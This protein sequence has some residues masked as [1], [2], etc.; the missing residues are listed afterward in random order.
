M[1]YNVFGGTLSHTLLLVAYLVWAIGLRP[2]VTDWG[3]AMS[4][5]CTTGSSPLSLSITPTLFH[6]KLKTHLFQKSFLP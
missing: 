1:T 6:S 4:A 5:S 3:S 2:N